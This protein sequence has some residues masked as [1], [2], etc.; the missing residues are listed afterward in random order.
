LIRLILYAAIVILVFFAYRFFKLLS[1]YKSGSRPD[2][3]D[4]KSRAENLK[5]KYKNVQEA[6][7]RDITSSDDES[8]SPSK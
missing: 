1:S 7:F 2:I 3:N 8:D 5:N 4:L 6:D